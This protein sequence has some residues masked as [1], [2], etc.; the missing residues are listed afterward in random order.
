ML[1]T[2]NVPQRGTW[3]KYHANPILGGPEL[4]TCFDVHVRRIETG[5]RMY[6]SWQPV[7]VRFLAWENQCPSR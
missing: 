2:E 3:K 5:Y 1:A 6:F 7:G 4:G